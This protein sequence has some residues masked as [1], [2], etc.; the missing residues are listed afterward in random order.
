M[1]RR[2]KSKGLAENR[3]REALVKMEAAV[4][5]PI[6]PATTLTDLGRHWI[7]IEIEPSERARSTKDRYRQIIE[8]YITPAIG[9]QEVREFTTFR[10]DAF[11]QAWALKHGAE[12]AN[13]VKTCLTGMMSLAVRYGAIKAN[14]LREVTRVHG[15]TPEPR[16]LT[17]DEVRQ[18]RAALRKDKKAARGDLPDVIDLM[19]ATGCRTGEMLAIRWEDVD[20]D[21]GA[22]AIAGKIIRHKGAGLVREQTK[23]R[24]RSRKPLASWALGMLTARRVNA[25]PGGEWDLVFPTLTERPREV[26]TI[27]RQFR[28]F[29]E[30]HPEW[31]WVVAKTFRKTGAR[32]RAT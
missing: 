24:K 22:V 25:L 10:A 9:G 5:G 2:A 15:D 1:E 17:V 23:G 26:T 31:A 21:R 29:R 11:L 3:L 7:A 12:S 28:N 32:L 14:P 8:N 19:L 13:L 30:R 18:L 20:L 6:T 27:D 4:T 16:A